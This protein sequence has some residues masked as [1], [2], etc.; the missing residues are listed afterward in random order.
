MGD[1][2][3]ETP[4]SQDD[5]QPI[6][7]TPEHR[8]VTNQARIASAI[9]N[10]N[11][12]DITDRRHPEKAS[13]KAAQI[14][15]DL[16][17]RVQELEGK[18]TNK[19]KHNDEHGSHATSRSRSRR[20][21]S[22]TRRH[23]R[24]DGRSSSRDHRHGKSPER[25]YNKK[26]NRSASQDL[27]NQH[28]SDEDRR[29]RNT[30]RT[31]NDHTIMGATPFTE[32]IL[33][34]KLPKGFD[35]PTDVKILVDTGADSNILF[36]GAFDKL[37]LRDENLQTHRNGITGLGDNFLKPEGS[38]TLPLT[39][40]TGDKRRTLIAEFVVLKDSTAYNVILGRKTINDFSAIIFTKYLLMK[41][42]AEDDSI[43]TIH[44]DREI[45][46]ECDNTSLALRKKSRD[47]A[48]I[49]LADLD[50]RQ[51]GQP[52]P[53]PEGDMEKLQIGQTKDEY[54][55]INRNLPYDLK[56]DL[57]QFLKQNRDLFAFTP[58][59]MPG[60]DPDFMSHRLAVNPKA[61]PVAQRRRKMSADRAAEVKRQVQALLEANFIRELPYTTWLANVV[62]V[63]KSNGKWRIFMDAYS[64]YNQIPM[65]RPDE[66]KTAF[67]T[68]DGTYCYTVMPFGLKNAGATYQRLVNKIF[69]NLSGTKLEVYIDDML[70]KTDSDEQLI[71]DLKAVT[72]TLRRHQMRLNPTKCA[73]GMEAGKF[74]GFM[75]TQRGV[76]ANPEKC[77]AVLETTSPKNLRDVQKLTGR[78]TALSRFLGASAQKAIPFF[79]LMKKGAPFVWKEECEMAFQHFKKTLA[80]PPILAKPQTGETLYLYLSITEETLAAALI[81]ENKKKEQKP[82]YFTSKVLQDAETRYSRLEKLAFA[83]LTASRRLRQ[84]FQAHRITV[85]TDQAVKQVLQK[86]DLAGRMLAWTVELSQFD[87]KFEPRYAI[88]AQA[89][90]DFIAEMTPGN[91]PPEAWK[92]HVDGSSNVTSGGAGVILESQNG[93]VIE[94]SVRYDFPVS[95]NQ[96]EYEALLA[97][98]TLASEVGAKILEVNT[99]SQVVSS[100]INGDY[101]T[102]DPLLQQYLAKVNKL[103]EEFDQIIIQHVPRERNARADLLS[104]LASTK[105]GH[106]NKSL[107]QEVVKTPSVSLTAD[108]HLTHSHHKSWTHPI[109]QYLLNREL[110]EDPKEGKRI[111]REAAGYTVV[112]GQLYKRGFSQPLLKCVE[113]GSTEYILR[114]IHE[115]CCGH[116]VG[117]K[118]LAQKVIRAGYF[119]PTII[120]DSMQLVKNCDKCQRHANIHQAAP[121]QLSIISAERPFGTWG[122]DLVGPFPTA[123]GQLRYLIVAIDYFT[124]WI[125]AEPLAS[126][127]ATQCRKFLWR[128]IITRFGIPE[129]IISDN[130]TQFADTKFKEF[131]NGLRIS[132]RFSSVEHPQTNG[133]MESAN[134]IIVKGLKKRLDEA[135]GLWADELGSVLWSYRTTPQ[136]ATGETPLRL[137]YGTEAIIPVEIGD[138]SPRRTIGGNDEEAERD[139]TGEIRSIAHLRELALKQ[140]ISLRYNHGVIRREFTTDDL[141]LR[142]NDIGPPTPGEGKLAPNW[143]GP[144]RIKA[145][146]GKGAY[147]LERLNGNEVPRTWNAA[148]LRRYYS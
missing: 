43:G 47:A 121:H 137:T 55:F 16:C 64:A 41:F 78:L 145:A 45:A 112:A 76:E 130:G 62:L 79:K 23:D 96:A 15:Q 59:D 86:P 114:E 42:V 40:G 31:R 139:L 135:K 98:L 77:R 19:G 144:Y 101:Q 126:I 115:G 51:D 132:H 57:S 49:F 140:R 44:G 108:T 27:S 81:R 116:H 28:H 4:S 87:I 6:N 29:D 9:Q 25:R 7:P 146:I 20:G 147:K 18:I 84:Y 102:R 80:E 88:K 122:I 48:G 110:P 85:R 109:L 82:I 148:N 111:K 123:P 67:I 118:T 12:R 11:D 5:S 2:L 127:T 46:A 142:R 17:L 68:P 125:E 73:F 107:I 106:G 72:D 95:N 89:M 54:T 8:E 26:H 50:A 63:K 117:G 93:V 136:T 14:I 100:Q 113:P 141:V 128:Q 120:R 53:E 52:R 21:R 133:Q 143:E 105:P 24:R 71:S 83:L 58:A 32:R 104:K 60:I 124:K 138:P 90:A 131:L 94:Q 37:G 61:K 13:D 91:I 103:K 22:P 34:A 56:E 97:G 70:A 3:E 69:Q 74:L 1:V 10:A 36:R 75:I 33:R 65:H 99:D 92:L 38:I 30:K 119:W 39:I 134:K 35:K 129:I 66:E